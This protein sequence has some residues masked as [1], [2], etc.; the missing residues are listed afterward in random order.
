MQKIKE[1]LFG[2]VVFLA[3]G[4]IFVPMFFSEN[5]KKIN[6]TDM[7]M[8]EPVA[9]AA[10]TPISEPENLV[11]LNQLEKPSFD[12]TV[13]QAYQDTEDLALNES[14]QELIGSEDSSAQ[15]VSKATQQAIVAQKDTILP[16]PAVFAIDTD[17]SSA[18][19]SE[20]DNAVQKQAS[21][22]TT[23]KVAATQQDTN[24]L[25]QQDDKS[26]QPALKQAK[27]SIE[28]KTEN[29]LPAKKARITEVSAAWVVQLATFKEG[30]NADSL[31]KN[32]QK[33]GYPAY[34]RHMQNSQGTY[35]L[36]LVGPKV[37]KA[38]ADSL[39]VELKAKYR[40]Q[41]VVIQHQPISS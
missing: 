6:L 2:A 27:N 22:G 19:T 18:I 38:E 31:V 7:Q 36:V 26:T 13:M 23:E 8:K 41:G 32:L 20:M 11:V 29:S 33:D 14:I 15:N 40:L 4:V 3:L 1:R 25:L 5:N 28:T 30:A 16:L 12:E 9:S 35:T 34:S 21:L 39:K 37:A 24:D 17:A 10:L